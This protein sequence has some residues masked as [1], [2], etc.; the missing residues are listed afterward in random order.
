MSSSFLL[1]EQWTGWLTDAKCARDPSGNYTGDIHQKH[2]EEGQPV[3]FITEADKKI[4]TLAGSDKVAKM[5]GHKVTLTG[6]TEA[7]GTIEVESA[8]QAR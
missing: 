4:H 1:A 6:K 8:T 2:V 3:V 7:N 5:V